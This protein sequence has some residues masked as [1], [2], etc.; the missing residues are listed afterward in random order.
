MDNVKVADDY[1]DRLFRMIFNDK[2]KLLEL[3]NAMNRSDYTDASELQVVTLEN[4]IYLSMKNDV[5]YVLHDELFLY[6]Q[7][8]T[9]NANMPLRC[10]FYASDTYSILVKDKN[11]YGTKMLPLPSPTFVVFY[12]GKQKMDEEG[13]LRLS[14][15][16]VKKQ[17][18]PNLEVIV[19]VKN[20]NMGNSRELFEKCRPMRDYMI[21]VDKVRR[22]SQEQPLEDAVERTIR[23]CME[24]DV[25]ADFLKR[26]RAEVVKMCLYEYDEERQREFDREEGREEGRQELLEEQIRA[27]VKKGYSKEMIADFLGVDLETIESVIIGLVEVKR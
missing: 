9:K 27:N 12:N 4:A 14:D 6:E 1:K 22:Y 17:E 24:E 18:I 21:F 11:L 7:Q 3:Y 5:A 25:M 20:I 13:E 19:K 2:E 16:F 15:A 26:N 10:L 23:E 8:S